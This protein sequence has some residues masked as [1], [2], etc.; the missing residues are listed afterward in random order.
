MSYFKYC[1]AVLTA[2]VAAVPL[3]AA[4]TE[5]ALP[6]KMADVAEQLNR[7]CPE[8][9]KIEAKK[10]ELVI[11]L[12]EVHGRGGFEGQYS[13][14]LKRYAGR[15]ADLMIDVKTENL[16][17]SDRKVQPVLGRIFFSGMSHNIH[18]NRTGWQTIEFK[19]LKLPGNGL[20]KW[21]IL[22]KN[23]SGEV[24]FRSPRARINLYKRDR[25]NDG[26]RK[27]K[28]DKKKEN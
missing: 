13:A 12:T 4:E 24:S 15:T 17:R 8:N 20:V 10:D 1:A 28:K 3:R 14:D 23:F 27:K 25:A 19:T 5:V 2:V 16:S 22:L 11:T 26:E 7:K 6:I 21:R 9:A 18:S